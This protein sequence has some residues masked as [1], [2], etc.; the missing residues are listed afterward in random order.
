VPNNLNDFFH[1]YPDIECVCF[2]GPKAQQQFMLIVA[3]GL[4][5]SR[6]VIDRLSESGGA[7]AASCK[8]APDL[9]RTL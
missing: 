8:S 9:N 7:L 3:P 1:E 5:A 6:P 4:A 2:N